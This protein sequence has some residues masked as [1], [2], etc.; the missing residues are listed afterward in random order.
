MPNGGDD[1]PENDAAA[2]AA[3]AR[4]YDWRPRPDPT[5]LTTAQLRETEAQLNRTIAE[6][7]AGLRELLEQRLDGMDQATILLAEQIAKIDPELLAGRAALRAEAASA[8]TSL[9]E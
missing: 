9:R 4:Q 8:I 2:A 6:R 3:S 1:V 7:V 5:V